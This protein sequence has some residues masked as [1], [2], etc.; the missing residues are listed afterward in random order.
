MRQQPPAEESL[1][2][3]Y[4]TPDEL[5]SLTPEEIRFLTALVHENLP[6]VSEAERMEAERDYRARILKKLAG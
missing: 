1:L 4:F 2:L 3:R 6:E 5:A